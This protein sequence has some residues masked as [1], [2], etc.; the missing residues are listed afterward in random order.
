M[1]AN[2]EHRGAPLLEVDGLVVRYPVAPR[3]R[4]DAR[5]AA[6][7]ARARRLGRLVRR[8]AR[9]DGRARRRVRLRQDD[10]GAGRAA[11]RAAGGRQRP[12][13]RRST[14]TAARRARAAAAA[15]AD[16]DHLPGS[17]RVARSA[18]PCRATV[19]E[20][21]VVHR[22]GTR[23]SAAAGRRGRSTQAGLSPAELY[24]GRY[25]HELSGGQR[26]RVAIAASLALGPE[27]LV[28]DEPVSMLDVS[29]RA[30]I[31]ADPRRAARPRAC[32]ADDH[33]RPLDR[34]ALRRPDLRHVPRPH[35]RGGAGGQVIE[36]P[37]HPY[38][39]ALLSVVP[40]RDPR[41][42]VRAPDPPRRGAQ[43]DRR[44]VGLPLPPPLPGRGRG[45]P[46]DRS[47]AACAGGRVGRA[48]RRLPPRALDAHP[49]AA[50]GDLDGVDGGAH[51]LVVE[52]PPA[53]EV[54]LPAVPG[55]A[56]HALARER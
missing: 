10:D 8:R 19:A 35:R 36:D 13:R 52:A 45:V 9:R 31:L 1:S 28:A 16:A 26:Q 53:L 54:E 27:L 30:G 21:L 41:R 18:L 47:G 11:A 20:A 40:R 34:G 17:V 39:K 14:S 12:L 42:R 15:P 24:L 55:A 7:A 29:V 49:H 2:G 3:A 56:E 38:T 43:S 44:A 33:A 50:V 25:P 23:G 5:A 6:E 51:A 4:G 48:P 37:Q 22:Q 32:G 46:H